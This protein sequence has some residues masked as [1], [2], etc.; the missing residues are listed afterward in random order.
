MEITIKRKGN[1]FVAL[2]TDNVKLGAINIKTGK[3]TGDVACHKSLTEYLE[4]F[5]SLK[6]DKVTITLELTFAD[7]SIS[8]ADTKHVE[9]ITRKVVKALMDECLCGDGI[10][11]EDA[12]TFTQEII[13]KCGVVKSVGSFESPIKF[14]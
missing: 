6:A 3:L 9:E 1:S 10:A 12:E 8:L 13:A 2:N 5:K 11:P 14:E 4:F 7:R